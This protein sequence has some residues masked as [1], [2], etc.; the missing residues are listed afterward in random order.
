MA[1][2]TFSRISAH[3]WDM[4]V[5]PSLAAFGGILRY[6]W[7]FGFVLVCVLA[8]LQPL[9]LLLRPAQSLPVK[10]VSEHVVREGVCVWKADFNQSASAL[11]LH[12]GHGATCLL[13]TLLADWSVLLRS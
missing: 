8:D 1:L 13:P 7:G 4:L 3:F 10:L 12:D 5:L 9:G 11:R 6:C 2:G